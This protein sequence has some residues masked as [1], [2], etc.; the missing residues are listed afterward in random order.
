VRA[1]PLVKS[2][3]WPVT[4]QPGLPARVSVTVRDSPEVVS[5]PPSG[6]STGDGRITSPA[7]TEMV[8][9]PAATS[10]DSASHAPDEDSH[11]VGQSADR[12]AGELRQR[13]ARTDRRT[14]PMPPAIATN[15][16]PAFG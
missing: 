7:S 12:E 3:T 4:F 9:A 15:P 11:G 16:S 5:T 14:V 2:V 6:A 8:S 1:E 13:S 10:V